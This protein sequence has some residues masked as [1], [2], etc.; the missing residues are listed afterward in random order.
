[1]YLIARSKAGNQ[2]L[3]E[4]FDQDGQ[5]FEKNIV[6]KL[7]SKHLNMKTN[8]L[9]KKKF[10][11]D[12][13]AYNAEII[14][15]IEVKRWD[16]LRFFLTLRKKINEVERDLKGVVDGI[17][18]TTKEGILTCKPRPSLLY[19]MKYIENN[20]ENLGLPDVE[21]RSMVITRLYPPFREYK[22]CLFLSYEEISN[23]RII[24]LRNIYPP[25]HV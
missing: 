16:F 15:V 6:P 20:K 1:M 25:K 23:D 4:K 12:L 24:E 22:G 21:V 13:I 18:Y 17:K 9:E 10:D 2:F 8:K 14:F 5:N 7:F 19:K 3:Q 11:I